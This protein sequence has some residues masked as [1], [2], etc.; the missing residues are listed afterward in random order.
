MSD[1]YSHAPLNDYP[2]L[3][4]IRFMTMFL[5]SQNDVLNG[6]FCFAKIGSLLRELILRITTIKT[7]DLWV[8]R[9]AAGC[10]KWLP[11]VLRDGFLAIQAPKMAAVWRIFAGQ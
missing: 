10:S 4:Q 6:F 7:A 3:Q 5:R 9:M 11:D 8:F 1:K 2:A